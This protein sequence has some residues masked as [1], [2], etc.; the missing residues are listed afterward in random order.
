MNCQT[1]FVMRKNSTGIQRSVWICPITGTTFC[2]VC[3]RGKVDSQLGS[4]CTLCDSEVVRE[5]TAIQG[6][7]NRSAIA[8]GRAERRKREA[9]YGDRVARSGNVLIMQAG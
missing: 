1:Y 6:G 7:S 5:F 9:Q 2:G 4:R 8:A 3:L